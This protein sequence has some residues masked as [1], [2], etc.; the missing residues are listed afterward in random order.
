M[1]SAILNST[2]LATLLVYFLMLGGISVWVSARQQAAQEEKAS[3][4]TFFLAERSV[5]W[6]AVAASVFS[7]NIG[8]EH[9]IGLCGSA[10]EQ[11]LSVAW[12]EVGAVPCILTLAFFFLPV[13]LNSAVVTLPDYLVMRYGYKCRMTVV[14]LSLALYV[15]TKISATLFAGEIILTELSGLNKWVAVVLLISGTALYTAL[16]GLEAVIYTEALQTLVLLVGGIVVLFFTVRACGGWESLWEPG[17][18]ELEPEYF[19]IY[20]PMDDPLFPWTGLLFGYYAVS[21]WYWGC[22]QVI[23]QRTLAAKNIAHAQGGAVGASLLKLLPLFLMIVPGIGAR[24][25]MLRGEFQDTA[26]FRFDRSYPWLVKNVVPKGLRGLILAGMLA[27]LMSSLASVFNSAATLFTIDVWKA[28]YPETSEKRLVWIGRATVLV[29][30][31][32]S[33]LWLPMIPLLG[34][35]L[36][37]IIQKPTAF[38]VSPI[39]A[40]YLWG[41]LSPR[42]NYRSAKI[43]LSLG[44][45]CGAARFVFEVAEEVAKKPRGHWFGVITQINF[46]HFSFLNFAFSSALL[47]LCTGKGD[48]DKAEKPPELFFQTK[49]FKSLMAKAKPFTYTADHPGV[50]VELEMS[51]VHTKDPLSELQNLVIDD[52]HSGE[53]LARQDLGATEALSSE[54][55]FSHAQ[56]DLS[57]HW[58]LN[59]IT[60]S[61]CCSVRVKQVSILS[62][63]ALSLLTFFF[64]SFSIW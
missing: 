37:L 47:F 15:F 53:G 22:D 40:L 24:V 13:Y 3:A 49:L 61:G 4:E 64:I 9:F 57:E 51:A 58:S 48:S 44:V 8:S 39:L 33:L 59:P 6:W 7:S 31:L 28:K 11:G 32:A 16:G 14:W 25:L 50:E 1:E 2:D 42:P 35:Q 21:L 10:A 38:M 56:H 30:A 12:F 63:A 34:D 43:T 20:K 55:E 17:L 5:A 36:F 54:R 29:L 19:H 62:A 27:S 26:D 46:L 18:T 23:V 45:L 52:L 41:M 60:D